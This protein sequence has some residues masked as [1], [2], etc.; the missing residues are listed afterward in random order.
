M[1]MALFTRVLGWE[2]DRVRELLEKVKQD[3]MNTKLHAYSTG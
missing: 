3:M 2:I 1:S